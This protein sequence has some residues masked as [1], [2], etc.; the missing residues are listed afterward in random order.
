MLMLSWRRHEVPALFVAGAPRTDPRSA[1][2]LAD[3]LLAVIDDTTTLVII[4]SLTRF[5]EV[6]CGSVQGLGL[7]L[8]IVRKKR[9][10]KRHVPILIDGAQALFRQRGVN[11]FNTLLPDLW[12]GSFTKIA[13]AG[14]GGPSRPGPAG[15]S[16]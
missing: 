14:P 13:G 6:P 2:E 3:A 8:K 1:E 5:G 15:S 11:Q 7:A 16:P 10:G 9:E 4:S 12:L